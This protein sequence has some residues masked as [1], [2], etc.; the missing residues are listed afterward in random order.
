MM[1]NKHAKI[2]LFIAAALIVSM[3]MFAG[4]GSTDPDG[5][6]PPN[7]RPKCYLANIPTEGEEYS[8]NPELYWYATDE[9]GFV[10]QYRYVVKKAEDINDDPLAFAESVLNNGDFD[11]WTVIYTDSLTP[12]QSATSNTVRLYAVADPEVYT[13]QYFFVQ[14]VDNEDMPS[15]FTDT[16]AT[17]EVTTLAYRMYSRN[18]N[19]PE[20]QMNVDTQR[21]Y[22]NLEDTTATY[23]GINLSWSGSDSLDYKRAQPPLEYH[24]R[25]FGPFP[26]RAEASTDPAKFVY[27]SYDSTTGSVWIDKESAKIYNLYRNEGISDMTRSDYF[28]FEVRA[29]DDAFVP[30]PTPAQA[31]LHIVE[32][33][34]EKGLMLVDNNSYVAQDYVYHS[35]APLPTKDDSA[36]VALQDYVQSVFDQAGYSADKFYFYL[37]EGGNPTIKRLP[38]FDTLLQYKYIVFFI[39]QYRPV[40]MAAEVIFTPLKDYLDLGGRVI[41]IGWNTFCGSVGNTPSLYPFGPGTLAYDYFGIQGEYFTAW[42]QTGENYGPIIG[43]TPEEMVQAEAIVPDMPPILPTDPEGNMKDYYVRPQYAPVEGVRFGNNYEFTVG[44]EPWV[45]YYVKTINAE[46]VYTARS[47]YSSKDIYGH[48]KREFQSIFGTT[49]QSIDGRVVGVRKS[50]SVYRTATF[51]FSLYSMPEPYAVDFVRSIMDWLTEEDDR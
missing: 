12:G 35:I 51:S 37:Q 11:D 33:G 23:N 17:G 2:L 21:I 29:R 43:V 15:N 45:S 22:F 18:N 10:S 26:S 8:F 9:D 1:H 30:D 20:T 36:V 47:V 46:A 38:G 31:V 14:A 48:D 49:R 25:V 39:E 40:N 16:N 28:L 13:P 50:T 27:E 34:F 44:A 3:L 32:P 4:C 42:N 5:T 7:A 6:L 19:P 24:W 41:F